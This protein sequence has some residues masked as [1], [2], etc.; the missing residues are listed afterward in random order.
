LEDGGRSGWKQKGN[1]PRGE[2]KTGIDN[3]GTT[4][5]HLKERRKKET[6][7]E[8]RERGGKKKVK[9]PRSGRNSDPREEVKPRKK[10]N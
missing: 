2:K 8:E 5:P 9:R 6:T 7:E 4:K 10:E 1:N 3:R